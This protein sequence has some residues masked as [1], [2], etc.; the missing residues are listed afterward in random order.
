M[1]ELE[2]YYGKFNEEKRLSSRHGQ[3][4]Y[5]TS[6]RM[7]HELLEK[8]EN[9]SILDVGAGTGRYAVSL[10]NEGYDVTAVELVKSNLGTLKAK[11]ST[12]KAYQGN[13]LDLKRFKD[14]SFDLVLLFGPLYHLY[15]KEDKL[16]AL[17]EAKRVAKDGGII[18]AAYCMNDYSIL[19]YGF[20]EG[21][22]KECLESGLV[23]ENFKSHG[24]VSTLYDYVDLDEIE[25]LRKESGLRR[26]FQYSSDG[27]AWYMRE[28]LKKMDETTFDL[29]VQYHWST[30][31]RVDLMGAGAHV[32]D[33]LIKE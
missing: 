15:T 1:N 13:A 31:R 22:I 16:K 27:A 9:P 33:V 2:Q 7:I 12:V 24:N 29:F 20:K 26:L 11:K 21:K 8:M 18:M 5:L 10:A 28:T 19:M 14:Q 6:M 3:V 32:V 25:E 30:C 4:E 17:C 23:D